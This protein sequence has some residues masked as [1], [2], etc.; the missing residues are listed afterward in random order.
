[1]VLGQTDMIDGNINQSSQGLYR[2]VYSAQGPGVATVF[3]YRRNFNWPHR[4]VY[5]IIIWGRGTGVSDFV[6]SLA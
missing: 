3:L 5:Y 6:A 2:T 1:M 4:C